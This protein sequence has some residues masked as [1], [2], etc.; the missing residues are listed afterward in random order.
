MKKTICGVLIASL[1]LTSGSRSAMA[2]EDNLKVLEDINRAVKES[3]PSLLRN[4]F[5]RQLDAYYAKRGMDVLLTALHLHRRVKTLERELRRTDEELLPQLEHAVIS[6][7]ELDR[8]AVSARFLVVRAQKLAA[9]AR[10][11]AADLAL[12]ESA[13]RDRCSEQ[14]LKF[15]DEYFT[16]NTKN[17]PEAFNLEPKAG[18]YVMAV[19]F[20]VGMEGK[21]VGTG[22]SSALANGLGAGGGALYA[23]YNP[24]NV[25]NATAIGAVV[26]LAVTAI[27]GFLEQKKYDKQKALIED[28]R[29]FKEITLAQETSAARSTIRSRCAEMLPEAEFGAALAS[30]RSSAESAVTLALN[31]VAAAEIRFQELERTARASLNASAERG[32]VLLREDYLT[33][34]D[35]KLRNDV[36]RDQKAREYGRKLLGAAERLKALRSSEPTGESLD[37]ADSLWDQV[38]EGDSAFRPDRSFSFSPSA[39]KERSTAFWENYVKNLGRDLRD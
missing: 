1:A 10:T 24:A 3:Y 9:E 30:Y 27:L 12:L 39:R 5:L 13:W 6:G 2:E 8:T 33:I 32:L 28:T 21:G 4:S 15:A 35:E 36:R 7:G 29:A 14:T 25:M 16:P 38:I 23:L 37:L 31:S 17:R 26:T 18:E 22:S 20:N 19:Q 11:I 34:A